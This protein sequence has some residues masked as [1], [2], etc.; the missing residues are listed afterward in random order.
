MLTSIYTHIYRRTD[1]CIGAIEL[2]IVGIRCGVA[3][4]DDGCGEFAIVDKSDYI[5]NVFVWS[6]IENGWLCTMKFE[7]ILMTYKNTFFQKNLQKIIKI[8][9]LV[10]MH[11]WR[12]VVE[13]INIYLCCDAAVLSAPWDMLLYYMHGVVCGIYSYV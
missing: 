2:K 3:Y 5:S 8:F 9:F 4:I 11:S 6:S 13:V 1:W 12:P 10:P 7:Q